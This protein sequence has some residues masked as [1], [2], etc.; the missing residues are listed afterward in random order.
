MSKDRN[1]STEGFD[2]SQDVDFGMNDAPLKSD[3]FQIAAEL[4]SIDNEITDKMLFS[5]DFPET[6]PTR[7]IFQPHT[8]RT[9][10]LLKEILRLIFQRQQKIIEMHGK[11]VHPHYFLTIDKLSELLNKNNSIPLTEKTPTHLDSA[12]KQ[13]IDFFNGGAKKIGYLYPYLFQHEGYIESKV[14]LISPQIEKEVSTSVFRKACFLFSLDAIHSILEGKTSFESPEGKLENILVRK[15]KYGP[16]LYPRLGAVD[17]YLQEI[18]KPGF[19]PYPSIRLQDFMD[20]FME[21]GLRSDKILEVLPDYHIINSQP[22]LDKDGSFIRE[23]ELYRQ[24]RMHFYSLEKYCVHYFKKISSERGFH[25]IQKRVQDYVHAYPSPQT[26]PLD[27]P[28]KEREQE[29]FSIIEDFPF[30]VRHSEMMKELQ[31]TCFYSLRLLKALISEIGSIQEKQGEQ[32]QKRFLEQLETKI[33]T[34]TKEKLTLMPIDLNA[35]TEAG[36]IETAEQKARTRIKA[37]SLIRAKYA[38]YETQKDDGKIHTYVVDPAYMTAVVNNLQLLSI[39][40]SSYDMQFKIARLLAEQLK[41]ARHPRLDSLIDPKE[42]EELQSKISQTEEALLKKK[43]KEEMLG[44]FNP[45]A[46]VGGF[47]LSFVVFVILYVLTDS[48]ALLFAGFIISI[49]TGG[50]FSILIKGKKKKTGAEIFQEMGLSP[51]KQNLQAIMNTG[52]AILFKKKYSSIQE[53][54]HDR[55]S[56]RQTIS[57]NIPQFKASSVYLSKMKND[58]KVISTIEN[59]ILLSSAVISV[60]KEILPANKSD[61]IVL[62][63]QDLKIASIR[64]QL[65]EFFKYEMAMESSELGKKYY[66]FIINSIEIDYSRYL[67]SRSLPKMDSLRN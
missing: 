28:T 56:L 2:F 55:K 21:Y 13:M 20:D 3:Q 66:N 57:A 24:I 42:L 65:V 44:R 59:A 53:K 5:K 63:K 16:W 60:P 6:N 43:K 1:N 17:Y 9:T 26:T 54:F 11:K 14:V 47:V 64:A 29:L 58:E 4:I 34:Y 33:Q 37:K 27:L 36:R 46:G 51:D 50:M 18:I 32:N 30:D 15:S 48:P 10:S 49:F 7:L 8:S 25:L 12:L 39:E 31:E 23:P 19:K 62:S 40:N 35:L 41:A 38:V 67:R 61:I 45:V 22:A 52:T